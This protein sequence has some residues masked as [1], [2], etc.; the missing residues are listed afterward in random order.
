MLPIYVAA[1]LVLFGLTA[2]AVRLALQWAYRKGC[3]E[4][5]QRWVKAAQL[6]EDLVEGGRTYHVLRLADDGVDE[7]SAADLER[8]ALV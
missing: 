6:G 4:T 7:V 5:S 3:H 1:N 2:M 8:P